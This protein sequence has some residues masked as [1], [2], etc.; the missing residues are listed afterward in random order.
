[1]RAHSGL[2]LLLISP[3]L[4]AACDPAP[5]EA[6]GTLEWDRVN[7][8]AVASEA[9]VEMFAHEGDRVA[10]GAP[11]LKL[12]SRLQEALVSRLK[13]VVV[14]AEWKL[15]KLE[16]G[17]RPEEVASAI[18]DAEAAKY[19]RQTMQLESERKEKVRSTGAVSGRSAD[20]SANSLAQAK[21]AE[22][23]ANERLKML[24]SGYRKE[25]VEQARAGLEAARAELLHATEALERY[26]V[27]AERAGVLDSLPFKLGDKPPIGAVVTTV[28]AGDTPWARVYLPE[29]WMS[30][31]K[32]GDTVEVIVDGRAGPIRGKVRYIESNASFTP[33]YTLSE[34]DRS[35]LSFVTQIDLD[36][37]SAKGLP[38][39]IPVRMRLLDE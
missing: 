19:N 34:D 32:P 28:L 33:Y 27:K 15:K 11:L 5:V 6:L 2:I 23:S 39:G 10:A 26:T 30:R 14:Q 20:L 38:L 1:M 35:R 13:A 3:F 9:I 37:E 12:D 31:V 7:G 8:R 36:T 4:L 22:R 18:A 29:P 25:E 17:Y 24:Q 21:A 16:A